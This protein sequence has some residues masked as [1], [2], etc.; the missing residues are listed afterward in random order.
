MT[1]LRREPFRLFFPLGVVLAWAGV[2]HWLAYAVGLTT[3]YS[4]QAHALVQIEGFL[5]AFATGFLLTAIPRRTQTPPPAVATLGVLAALQLVTVIASL[6]ERW[7]VAALAAVGQIGGLV[8]F[9]ARRLTAARARRPPPGF[10]LV[11]LALLQGLMGSVLI[12][13]TAAYGWDALA[14]R[15]GRL[16]VEQGLFLC[17]VAGVGSLVL[18]LMAGAP[19]PPDVGSSQQA[20]RQA[21]WFGAAGLAIVATLI[22]EVLGWGRVAPVLRG[23][24]VAAALVVGGGAARRPQ[25]PGWNRRLTWI[26]LWLV[27]LGLV[28]SGLAP[29]YRVPA[30]H[31]T[32]IGGFAL[33]AF[34]VATHVTASHLDLPAL[35][36]GRSPV[37]GTLAVA[38]LLALGAR[39]IADW[40]QTYFAHLGA[41][42]VAWIAGTL[43]WA[44]ALLPAWTGMRGRATAPGRETR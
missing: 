1:A 22:A 38:L 26:A 16:L 15:L 23:V 14:D 18:P 44:A 41:A 31:V 32:F 3:T 30:L 43:V 39:F 29:D 12:A 5:L 2:G 33:L 40:S 8:A 20:N 34:C 7:A 19:P 17:L 21:V 13:G 11:P 24:V 42:A 10:V 36:D 4:C 35:R 6:E 37:I 27:P 25:Q 28:A 9:A